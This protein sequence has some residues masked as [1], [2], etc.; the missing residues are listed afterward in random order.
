MYPKDEIQLK[1]HKCGPKNNDRKLI[2]KKETPTQKALE[3]ARKMQSLWWSLTSRVSFTLPLEFNV[4]P[5]G[6]FY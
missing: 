5:V 2:R 3:I 6:K 4:I 1:M